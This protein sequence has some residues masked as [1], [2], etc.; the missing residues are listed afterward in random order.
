MTVADEPRTLRRVRLTSVLL[1]ARWFPLRHERWRPFAVMAV[2]S[3]EG[4]EEGVLFGRSDKWSKS[5]SSFGSQLGGGLDLDLT[6]HVTVGVHLA[7][8]WMTRFSETVGGRR[9]Y[10]GAEFRV[11]VSWR[12]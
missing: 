7:Y 10:R 5:Q 1:G 9:Q 4:R 2:G 3:F 6:A 12:L 11:A 8:N